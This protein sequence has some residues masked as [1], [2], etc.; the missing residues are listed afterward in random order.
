MVNKNFFNNTRG[1]TLAELVIALGIMSIVIA[2]IYGVSAAASR[3]ATKNEVAAEVMQNLRTSMDFMEQDIRMAGLDRFGL[4]SAGIVRQDTPIPMPSATHLYFTADRNMNDTINN[5]DNSDGITEEGG[6]LDR[7]TYY[8]DAANKQL[9]Q[10]LSD[11]TTDSLCETVAENVENFQFSYLDANNAQIPFPIDTDDKLSSIRTVQVSM[12]I[13]EPA[14]A[15]GPVS[16][17]L[18]KRI[19]CRNIEF[20]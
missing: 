12:T 4:A 2:A 7:I 1:F 14:S 11:D 19:I 16:R 9:R 6:D 15:Y 18:T 20:L 5:Y 17:T 13:Q 10:C 3:S 8:Y